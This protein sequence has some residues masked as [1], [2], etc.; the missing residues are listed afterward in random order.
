MANEQNL[1]PS[2]KGGYQLTE[3][4]SKKGQ[5]KSAAVRREKKELHDAVKWILTTDLS[6]VKSKDFD[7]GSIATI[8]KERGL[9]VNKMTT[10][11]MSALGLWFGSVLGNAT[12]FKT[13][14]EYN[15]EEESSD[16]VKTPTLKIEISDN[17]NLEKVLYEANRHNE[18]D[19]G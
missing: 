11:K 2:T 17:S 9:D 5:M 18:N 19:E 8:M 1:I 7:N 16:D 14:G 3:E 6:D 15:N 4:D 10:S 13:L 12:N